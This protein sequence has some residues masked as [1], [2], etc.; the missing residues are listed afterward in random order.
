MSDSTK[1]VSS[2]R[3]TE[4]PAWKPWAAW[5]A[6]WAAGLA[7]VVPVELE[8]WRDAAGDGV[9]A[10]LVGINID[11]APY[12]LWLALG[13]LLAP[14]RFERLMATGRRTG[15][16]AA[17]WT[18]PAGRG[19]M[20]VAISVLLVGATS[21][22]AS[23]YVAS[24]PVAGPGAAEFGSLPPA[25]HDEYSYLFQARTFA[26]GQWVNASHASAARLFDQMH[27]LNDEG[28]FASRYFPGVGAWMAPFVAWGKPTWGHFLAGLITAVA[29]LGVGRELAGNGVG[30]LAGLLTAAAPGMALFSNLLLSH[31]P[32]LAGL[33]VFVYGFLRMQRSGTAV[34]GLVAGFG[35]TLAML[36]R[37]LTAAAMGLPF[38]CWLAWWWIRGGDDISADRRRRHVACVGVPV[39]LGMAVMGWYNH[40][41]TGDWATTPYRVFTDKHTPRHI[42]GFDNVVHGE[43]RI[44]EM[45]AAS[46]ERVLEHY[47]R[48]AENLDGELAVR[49]VVSRVI[50]SGKW[51]VGLVT[52]LMTSVVLLVGFLFGALPLPGRRWL[53]I[54]LAIVSLHLAHVPYWYAGIMNW[55]YVFE[56]GPFWCL[57]VAGVTVGLWQVARR[58]GRPGLA[59]AWSGLLLVSPVTSYQ[60]FEPVWSPSRIGLAVGEVGFAR[61]KHEEFR[62]LVRQR[63]K[64]DR[65]L[66]LVDPDPADR[67]IDFVVNEP[68][69][70][71]AVLV[72][73]YVPKV[74]PL[75][76]VLGTF[77]QRRVFVFEAQTGR[78]RE[79]R[80]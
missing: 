76:K 49:N 45:D 61:K 28:V 10:V 68:T 35:L 72:G 25:F 42:F 73:R 4:G 32:A 69:L 41:L 27:V 17:W 58:V 8:R 64:E 12:L 36:C 78:L 75:S 3:S 26:E 79:V 77:P 20:G 1:P 71:A 50:E 57:L 34:F 37:P 48:W 44:A 40:Q 63:V 80:R 23:L 21:L 18:A 74:V 66:V 60:S 47:D 51:T 24:Y 38:G 30:L 39:L 14:W 67:H 13:L 29:I 16:L 46:R 9:E 43:Q 31:H 62:S 22:T 2:G 56:S 55:H 52:L 53:P 33:S 6:A 54:V 5:L 65:A 59:L 11:T 15:R 19:G 7:F 70:D